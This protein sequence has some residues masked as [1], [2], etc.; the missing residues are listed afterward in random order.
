MSW[1]TGNLLQLVISFEDRSSSCKD[2]MYWMASPSASSMSSL[3][4]LMRFEASDSF[5]RRGI[6]SRARHCTNCTRS[7]LSR[8][9]SSSAWNPETS[10]SGGN[11]DT[12]FDAKFRVTR[13]RKLE[14]WDNTSP[15]RPLYERSK[16]CKCLRIP[17]GT[18]SDEM[19]LH[20]SA[21]ED[22]RGRRPNC[23]STCS[24]LSLLSLTSTR[25]R[26]TKN[27]RSSSATSTICKEAKFA[28]TTSSGV[29]EPPAAKSRNPSNN[30]P[31]STSSASSD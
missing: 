31:S 25:S 16:L 26:C 5:L 22:S 24:W 23:C 4:R 29:D 19:E 11:E 30:L 9:S 15:W 8:I 2:G 18:C 6:A 13:P 1:R 27:V 3:R 21:S 7:L 14:S 20:A 28:L 17:G 10:A 12:Q